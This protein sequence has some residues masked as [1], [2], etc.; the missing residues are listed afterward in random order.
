MEKRV[1]EKLK[2]IRSKH[3]LNDPEVKLAIEVLRRKGVTLQGGEIDVDELEI[4]MGYIKL[5]SDCLQEMADLV[6]K[7]YRKVRLLPEDELRKL[8]ADLKDDR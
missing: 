1:T 4:L 3:L 2:E 7:I 5:F 8:I 6:W